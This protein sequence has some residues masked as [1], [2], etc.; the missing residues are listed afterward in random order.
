M[1]TA[2]TLILN[3]AALLPTYV[4]LRFPGVNSLSVGLLMACYPLSFLVAA[5]IVGSYMETIGRKTCV[6]TGMLV[7]ALATLTFGLAALFPSVKVFFAVSCFARVLQGIA[8]AAVSVA[9]PGIITKE[10]P[11]KQD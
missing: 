7:M 10:F 9:I 6:V 3:V 2:D 1:A 4:A 5:P 8:D 11:E